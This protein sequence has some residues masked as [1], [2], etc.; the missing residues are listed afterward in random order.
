MILFRMI[1]LHGKIIVHVHRG[2]FYFFYNKNL[3]HRVIAKCIFSLS[4]KIIFLSEE[5]VVK[6]IVNTQKIKILPNTLNIPEIKLVKTYGNSQFIYISN[7]IREKGII[8]LLD[9]FSNLVDSDKKLKTFGQFVSEEIKVEMLSF[10]S[11]NITINNSVSDEILKYTFIFNSDCLILPSYNEGQPLIIL[12]AMAMGTII[13]ASGV[14]D[15]PNMLGIHYPLLILPKNSNSLQL[16]LNKFLA[17][18]LEERKNLSNYL[19]NRYNEFYSLE[20]HREKLL[21]IFNEK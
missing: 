15:I 17:F 3:I 12:E 20:N 2:D 10:Y 16:A 9:V 19:I 13:I 7:Y 14:G 4:S 21:S 11:A 5:F 18:G 8:E 1:N 6:K